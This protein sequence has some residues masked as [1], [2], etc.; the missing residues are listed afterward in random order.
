MNIRMHRSPDA[1]GATGG[2]EVVRDHAWKRK[3]DEQFANGDILDF[4]SD[5]DADAYLAL[6]RGEDVAEEVVEDVVLEEETQDGDEPKPESIDSD[7]QTPDTEVVSPRAK[8]MQAVGAKSE[9]EYDQKV[10]EL[11]QKLGAQGAELGTKAKE[12][13]TKATNQEAL[14][15]QLFNLVKD[16]AS[17][18]AE[19]WEYLQK[20]NPGLQMDPRIRAAME[21][22]A[23]TIAQAQASDD[24]VPD[25][26]LDAEGY[27][28]LSKRLKDS[29]SP[30][31][32]ELQ[33]LRQFRQT[34][35]TRQQENE[36]K[37]QLMQ[38]QETVIRNVADL[39]RNIPEL[40]AESA[41]PEV[42]TRMYYSGVEGDPIDPRFEPVD[43]FLRYVHENGLDKTNMD[44]KTI[45][46]RIYKPVDVNEI[47][48]KAREEERKKLLS[49]TQSVGLS[50]VRERGVQAEKSSNY[51]DRDWE[52]MIKSGNLPEDFLDDYGFVKLDMIPEKF[53]EYYR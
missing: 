11:H 14:N 23:Q 20:N 5:E 30:M 36:D 41:D 26:I 53:H 17:G 22:G 25:D 9:E 51:T 39:I 42:L 24:E 44:L 35:E 45:Y 38:Q 47:A 7:E 13:E 43:K 21:Q 10:M 48:E 8:A 34:W 32:Q 18:K 28:H 16:L 37:R 12:W 19:A 27:R 50:L 40:Q 1:K 49:R 33:E 4:E 31:Q 46:T 15:S 6:E 3:L 2:S 52:Q 29:L